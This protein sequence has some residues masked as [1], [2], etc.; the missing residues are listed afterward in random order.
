M[1]SADGDN[2]RTV[3]PGAMASRRIVRVVAGPPATCAE[4]SMTQSV[5]MVGRR[6]GFVGRVFQTL[7][8]RRCIDQK[9]P[10]ASVPEYDEPR[11]G[12]ALV[13]STLPS[14]PESNCA[15]DV[16]TPSDVRAST[17]TSLNGGTPTTWIESGASNRAVGWST[18]RWSGVVE[19]A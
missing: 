2:A 18:A 17:V 1:P 15:D 4:S 6:L 3:T 8:L 10:I 16:Q 7:W 19:P 11:V 9:R 14:G 13:R 12:A 5:G